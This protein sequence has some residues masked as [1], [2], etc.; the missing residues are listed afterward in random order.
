MMAGVQGSSISSWL[1]S[2]L[3]F[4]L[5]KPTPLFKCHKIEFK[6]IKIVLGRFATHEILQVL[7]P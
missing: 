2:S 6:M 5:K 3:L 1:G 4:Y 7:Y